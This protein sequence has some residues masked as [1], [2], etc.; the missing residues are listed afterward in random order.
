[1]VERVGADSYMVEF[2]A[3]SGS[4]Q[5]LVTF[6]ARDIR[7]CRFGQMLPAQRRLEVALV[8]RRE[9][10]AREESC[11]EPPDRMHLGEMLLADA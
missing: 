11:L 6:E 2:V 9:T 10:K 1:M 4:T 7:R 8:V 5:A 3:G